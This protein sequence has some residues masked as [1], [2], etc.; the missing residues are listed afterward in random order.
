MLGKVLPSNIGEVFPNLIE[1]RLQNN[2]FE[3]SIP[4]SIS[5]LTKLTPLYL[6]DNKFE[7]PI[8]VSL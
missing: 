7:G 2:K 4:S 1:L 3:G 8:P 6:N 5:T